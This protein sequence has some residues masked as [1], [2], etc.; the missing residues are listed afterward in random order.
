M[1][2]LVKDLDK[3]MQE[4]DV[5]EKDSQKDYETMMADSAEKRAEDAKLVAEKTSAKASEGV[6][7][8]AEKENKAATSKELMTTLEYIKSL[9]GECDWLMQ[10]YAVRKDARTSE[11]ESLGKA[12]AVLSGS[13]Y[14]LVQTQRSAKTALRR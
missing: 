5:E 12:K 11:I 4:A 10:Y 9:H 2:L 1:D 13:D 8:E 6:S 7:L 14:S 3:E